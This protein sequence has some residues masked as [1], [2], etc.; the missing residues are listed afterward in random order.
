MGNECNSASRHDM[1]EFAESQEDSGTGI[2][3]AL[4]FAE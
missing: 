2:L 1:D 4:W 3:H